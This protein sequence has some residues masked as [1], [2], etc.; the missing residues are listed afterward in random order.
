MADST[1][2]SSSIDRLRAEAT[3]L[4]GAERV[5]E[6]AFQ[7]ALATAAGALDLVSREPLS[8]W[9]EEPFAHA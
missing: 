9:D 1:P 7:A 3:A 5:A 2:M 4:Y 8:P 6:A